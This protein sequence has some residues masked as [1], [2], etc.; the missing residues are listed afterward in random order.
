MVG[1]IESKF[2][3]KYWPNGYTEDQIDW[4]YNSWTKENLL[5]CDNSSLNASYQ[6]LTML[7]TSFCPM[8]M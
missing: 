5:I 4:H 1:C 3:S 7:I 2:C 8:L 6:Q